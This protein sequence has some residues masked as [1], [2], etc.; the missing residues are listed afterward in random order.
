MPHVRSAPGPMMSTNPSSRVPPAPVPIRSGD[1]RIRDQPTSLPLPLS[2]FV[3]REDEAAA[4]VAV[5]RQP[6]VRLVS[7]TGPGGIG[8]TRLALSVATDLQGDFAD[9]IG[10]VPL[11]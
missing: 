2:S 11:A 9:G 7:L 8:K 3:G 10:F 6:A 5:L 4:V 1:A